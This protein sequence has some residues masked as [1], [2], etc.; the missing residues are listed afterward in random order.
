M[1]PCGRRGIYER[2][3]P[4]Q[5]VRDVK[6]RNK[7]LVIL[8]LAAGFLFASFAEAKDTVRLQAKVTEILTKFPA[9]SPAEKD[10]LAAELLSLGSDGIQETC[11]RLVAPGTGDDSL[12]RYAL[13]AAAVY[14][15][16]AGA[17]KDRRVFAEAVIESLDQVRFSENK[18]F[19]ISELQ[20]A[21][22]DESVK[23]LSKYLE[24]LR[25]CEPVAR[26]LVTIKTPKAEKALLKALEADSVVNPVALIK[27]LGEFRSRAAVKKISV[28]AESRD[29]KTR[30]VA[31]YALANIG[32]PASQALLENIPVTASSYERTSA[33]SLYLLYAQRLTESGRKEQ[34][35]KISH[36]LIRNFT[37]PGESQ[38]RA[39]ALTLLSEI[40]GESVLE[41]LLQAVE[42]PDPKYR[43]RVLE[44]AEPIKGEQATARWIEKM[45]KFP[46]ET[47]ADII[48][49]LGRRGDKS[50]YPMIREKLKSEE[51]AV[52]LAAIPAAARLGG[53]EI[54]DDLIPILLKGEED[55][56]GAVKLALLGLP[57]EIIVPKA[58]GLLAE[59]PPLARPALIEILAERKARDYVDVVLAQAKNENDTVRRSALAAL[60]QIVRDGD[61]PQVINL[62]LQTANSSEIQLVQNAVVSAANQILD[63]ERRADQ[64]LI[65]LENVKGAKRAN[66]LRPL[67]RIGGELALQ[68]VIGETKNGDPQVRSVAIYALSNWPDSAAIEELFNIARTAEDRKFRYLALQG[69]AR[70]DGVSAL[71]P[72]KRLALLREAMDLAKE[73]GEKNLLLTG[74]A[75]IKTLESLTIAA[76]FLDDPQLQARAAQAAAKIALPAPGAEGLSGFDVILILKKAALLIENEYDRENVENYVHTLLMKEGFVPLFNRKNITGWKGLV[77][78]PVSRARMTPKRLGEEQKKADREMRLHWKVIDGML[79]F[80]GKGHS[81]C[82]AKDYADFEMFVDWKIEEKGD[83]G[84]YLRG[85]PQV[86]IW[87]PAQWPEGSG[88]LYNNK[89][90]PSK[91]LLPVDRPV[92]EWNSFYIKMIGE[93]V[94]V[95][96]NGA[97]VVDNVVL[98]NY[99]ERD[100][101]IYPAGQI[102][103]QAHSTPL[104]FK[105]V[106]IREIA[107]EKK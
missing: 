22:K 61:L 83:S 97:L 82:T 50:A 62:L 43:Q 38:V 18:T 59:A 14:A 72:E 95:Y 51:K 60:E 8:F 103:L 47:Q 52:R 100:K 40:V 99:W 80:D 94:T 2:K 4:V 12:A 35:F 23:P 28:Y 48:S 33:A 73:T 79:A 24:D 107:P 26:A 54:I 6:S 29:E 1:S 91:P 69:I 70:L 9:Q 39:A 49:M 44:L 16:R 5:K 41:D 75:N 56:V 66:L 77:D 57:S 58:A 36:D 67:A 55:E 17:E 102:E 76:T 106:Y 85:S 88:G 101:P 13:D 45:T 37:A 7:I 27:A 81:L 34:A 10:A 68:T 104:Y 42:S 90:G 31:L 84:I 71:S 78:D 32:D 93:R 65:A 64:V 3:R 63:P 21:G 105:N 19:L 98:E 92:G 46:A 20:L 15:S 86:Q 96:L 11:R 89:I 74:I 87:D 53:S 30:Q 25:L